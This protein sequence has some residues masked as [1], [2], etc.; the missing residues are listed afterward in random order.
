MQ[1]LGEEVVGTIL[2]PADN[3]HEIM[4]M[5]RKQLCTCL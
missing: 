5:F 1:F 2:Q 4:W 3:D